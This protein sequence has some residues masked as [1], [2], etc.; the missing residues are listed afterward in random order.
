MTHSCALFQFT[1]LLKWDCNENQEEFSKSQKITLLPECTLHHHN[2]K[3]S[4]QKTENIKEILNMKY[5]NET[6]I[7]KLYLPVLSKLGFHFAMKGLSRCWSKQY[8]EWSHDVDASLK[9]VKDED[10]QRERLKPELRPVKSEFR[11]WRWWLV[12]LRK[13]EN[14]DP[15]GKLWRGRNSEMLASWRHL[16][17]FWRETSRHSPNMEWEWSLST[18]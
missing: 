3:S 16:R 1:L 5:M 14:P 4:R 6:S 7:F 10:G 8:F 11:C 17:F 18:L 9:K 2:V 13:A 15:C 12:L